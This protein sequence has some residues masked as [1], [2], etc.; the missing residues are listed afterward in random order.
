[1]NVV[2][3]ASP[4]ID[5]VCE[6]RRIAAAEVPLEMEAVRSRVRR[7]L[8]QADEALGYPTQK[9]LPLLER[10]INRIPN[11]EYGEYLRQ[12]ILEGPHEATPTLVSLR[13]SLK[14]RNGA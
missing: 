11:N 14:L 13:K 8:Q 3:L 9:P 1:M 4:I 6:I 2:S 10:I 5:Y 12:V 7:L